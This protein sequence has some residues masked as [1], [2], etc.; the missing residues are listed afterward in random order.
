VLDGGEFIL[1]LSL[2][3]SVEQ[4]WLQDNNYNVIMGVRFLP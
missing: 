1:K 3:L 4:D 2:R